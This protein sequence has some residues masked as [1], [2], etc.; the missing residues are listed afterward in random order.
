M[1]LLY[2][3]SVAGDQAWSRVAS[4]DFRKDS[5]HS[6]LRGSGIGGAGKTGGTKAR[7][8]MRTRLSGLSCSRSTASTFLVSLSSSDMVVVVEKKVEGESEPGSDV[9]NIVA[10]IAIEL[11]F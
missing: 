6:P 5:G 3:L 4:M 8:W 1:E 10:D 7:G 2:V 11:Q 9:L